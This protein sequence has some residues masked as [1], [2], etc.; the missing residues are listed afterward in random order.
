MLDIKTWLETTG[1]KAAEEKFSKPPALPY[2]IFTEE[3]K[4]GGADNKNCLADR[5]LTAEMYS[6]FINREAESKIEGL[7]NEKSIEYKRN[8]TWIDS[9]R[10]YQTVY[11]FNLIE[12]I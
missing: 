12:K 5:S 6:E 11:D 9:E 8:R 3:T 4:V 2:I 7:L 1:L 10:Y